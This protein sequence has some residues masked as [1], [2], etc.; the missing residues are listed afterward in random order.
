MLNKTVTTET[1]ISVIVVTYNSA[2]VIGSCLAAL[3]AARDIGSEVFVIDNA[4]SDGSA[5]IV[6]HTFPSVSLVANKENVGFAAANNQVIPL[7]RGRYIF[8]LNPDAVISPQGLRAAMM[9]MDSHPR[10]GL[11]GTKIVNPDGSLQWSVSYRYPGQG[12]AKNELD[13]LPGS[14]ACVLGASM[15][16]RAEIIERLQGF[17]D[18]FFLY[19]EDQDLCLRVRK[20]GY[21]IG[22]IDSSVVTHVGGHSEKHSLLSEVWKKKIN[23]EYLFYRKHYPPKTVLRI[24]RADAIKACWR[25]MTLKLTL[26]LMKDKGHAKEKLEKYMVIR[27]T[28][29][30]FGPLQQ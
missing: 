5:A 17:D 11:A 22:Y 3:L 8:F 14:I 25:I 13:S 1:D 15:I 9:Y 30:N 20:L 10:I 26:P 28:V 12:Y 2:E 19:G 6:K 23:A 29:R 7:C 18:D 24:K 16:A 27:H 4:S 21:E